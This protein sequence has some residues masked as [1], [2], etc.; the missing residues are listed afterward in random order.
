M[1]WPCR[2]RRRRRHRGRGRRGRQGDEIRLKGGKLSIKIGRK[3]TCQAFA[4]VFPRPQAIDLRLAYLQQTLRFDPA[5]AVRG[6]KRKRARTLQS[7]FGAAGKRAQ[8]KLLKQLP[9]ALAFVDRKGGGASSSAFPTG[10]AIASAGCAIGPAGPQGSTGGATIGALGDNGGFVEAPVGNGLTVRITWVSCG[11]A[12]G[13]SVPECPKANGDVETPPASGDF[14][15]T[16]EVR[17]GERLVSRNSSHFEDTSKAEGRVGPD[18]KLRYVESSTNR[19][20]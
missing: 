10:P 14:Q 8:K 16:I 18:A 5:K 2:D 17:E 19:W 11:G 3:R 9:K 4:K 13:F 12:S 6:K 20:L 7:G 1:P 15:A